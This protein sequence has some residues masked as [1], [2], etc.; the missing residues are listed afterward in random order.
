MSDALCV[1]FAEA[2]VEHGHRERTCR[3]LA[4]AGQ[5][6][7]D[8]SRR[9]LVEA[10]LSD[11][12]GPLWFVRAG[13]WPARRFPSAP[14]RFPPPSATGRA[15]CALGAV[16]SELGDTPLS[17]E[18]AEWSEV[19]Q[20]TG[21]DF[22]RALRGIASLPSLASA[23]V[24]AELAARVL[25]D[26]AAGLAL[27]QSLFA[28]SS[29]ERLRVLRYAPLDVHS[30]ERLRVAQL[31]TSLQRGGAERIGLDLASELPQA[32]VSSRLYAIYSPTRA[33]FEA[34]AGAAELAK[35]L[36]SSIDRDARFD[37]L[38]RELALDGTDL[39][40]AHLLDGRDL[41]R[42]GA[43]GYRSV[44][45]VHN[46]SPGFPA[47]LASVDPAHLALL[48]GCSR[49]VEGDLAR[50]GL[51]APLRTVWNGIRV[52][53]PSSEV[54]ERRRDSPW[55]AELGLGDDDVLLLA[56]AN[57]RPQKR[58]HL[59]PSILAALRCELSTSR[60]AAKLVIAGATS[61]VNE[62]ARQAEARLRAE[63]ERLDV[64]PHVQ[65]A[66]L[67]SDVR[68]LLEASD[69]VLSPSEHEGLSLAHLEALSFGVPV[70]ATGSGGTEEIAAE[71]TAL[72]HLELD[73]SAT[74]WA[75]AILDVL[76]MSPLEKK[77]ARDAVARH[78][79]VKRMAANYARLYPR[80]LARTRPA[81]AGGGIVLVTNNFS[82]G[83]AQSSARRLLLGLR[84]QGVRA[85][86]VVIEEQTAY[87]TPG[88]RALCDAG[89]S[90]LAL[91]PPRELE[92]GRA[93]ERLLGELERDSPEA[94]VLWNVIPEYKL[95]IADG[96]LDVPLFDVSP[97]EMYFR[98]LERYF[99]STRRPSLP[100]RTAREYG[101]RLAGV[102]VKYAAEASRAGQM[103]GAP[104][105]VIPN[106]VPLGPS[107]ASAKRRAPGP[108]V[109]G[110]SARIHPDKKLGELLAALRVAAERL[111]PHVLRIAGAVDG[112]AENEA[113]E[114]RRASVG[115][116]VEWLGEVADTG[117]FLE[118]LDVF[119]LIAEPAGCPNASLEAM[120][121]GLPVIATDVGG[122]SEQ[123]VDGVTGRLI[124]RGDVEGLAL[125]MLELARRPELAAGF[126]RAGRERIERQFSLERM[127]RDYMSVCLR[128]ARNCGHV[129]ERSSKIAAE[130]AHTAVE[131]CA[132]IR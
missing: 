16:V 115:L 44:V 36:P 123:I 66:G 18:A 58:L 7:L 130:S 96:L 51:Q 92:P 25:S 21:G 110:T 12:R 101:A 82:T 19:L 89:V 120:E 71:A 91:P 107:R 132:P 3:A 34:P 106:G 90:V 126:G 59:L 114:L 105:H 53:S 20:A 13:T 129:L 88:R 86:A 63:V 49:A 100:Y 62:L 118:S 10:P 26:L 52:E 39:V 27:G 46:T 84:S 80:A 45:T 14:E 17:A 56:L 6:I 83:G 112:R 74:V 23:Y 113:A 67:V 32:G 122:M 79:N 103:L 94:V 11:L 69:V 98:S 15:V 1:V 73:S 109:F 70:I 28:Q 42:L 97:G 76:R 29:R 87:P 127:V 64:T 121:R 38:T 131:R 95:L 22:S 41:E 61:P 119:V 55:R 4:A 117:A 57:P 33:P 124:P 40:H 116:N 102:I 81:E 2:P 104:V 54:G 47:G 111:P 5:R 85:R 31:V 128:A 30:S 108:I 9:P 75:R 50:S 65:W 68:G 125:A 37:F 35:W 48:V 77:A 99:A 43:R 93:V 24:D 60:R 72:R 78:F 8:C